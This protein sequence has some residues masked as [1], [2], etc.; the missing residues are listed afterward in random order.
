MVPF[1]DGTHHL[2]YCVESPESWFEDFGSAHLVHGSATVR[3]DAGFAGAVHTDDYH[4]FL[5]PEADSEGLYLSNKTPS[6]F[7]VKEQREGLSTLPFSYRI[8]AKR[9]DIEAPRLKQVTP[10][11]LPAR[12]AQP[13]PLAPVKPVLPKP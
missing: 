4:V 12:P 2:L 1:P 8:V 13:Q 3:L 6:A 9:R 7:T 10:K 5:T 11:V